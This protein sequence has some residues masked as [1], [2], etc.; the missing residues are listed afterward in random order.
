ME[1]E[2]LNKIITYS[3]PREGTGLLEFSSDLGG[4]SG[5][6]GNMEAGRAP[7][8]TG[9]TGGGTG[10]R[11]PSMAE[12]TVWWPEA[13]LPGLLRSCGAE[14]WDGGR[15]MEAS[16]KRCSVKELLWCCSEDIGILVRKGRLGTM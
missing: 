15:E 16:L 5:C 13:G 2:R 9:N 7:P 1:K 3:L 14:G 10:G 4:G 11:W 6:W 12:R 8:N